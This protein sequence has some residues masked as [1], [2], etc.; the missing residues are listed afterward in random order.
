MFA[1][2]TE[3][4]TTLTAGS[5]GATAVCVGAPALAVGFTVAGLVYGGMKLVQH[6]YPP[7]QQDAYQAI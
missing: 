6:Y 3:T 4:V 1:A 7:T 5:T 2:A